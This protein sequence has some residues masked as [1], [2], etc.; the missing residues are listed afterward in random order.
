MLPVG[1]VE[2]CLINSSHIPLDSLS[3]SLSKERASV[4]KL[5]KVNNNK[6]MWG[7][8]QY[9]I[10]N[11]TISKKRG[12]NFQKTTT[13]WK[14]FSLPTNKLHILKYNLN[15][16]RTWQQWKHFEMMLPNYQKLHVSKKKIWT[17]FT[18]IFGEGSKKKWDLSVRLIETVWP[19]WLNAHC[20]PFAHGCII[21]RPAFCSQHCGA[22]S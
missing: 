16:I 12:L 17:A 7:L 22:S 3:L 10:V 20:C 2:C 5:P 18:L 1:D 6:T 14:H 15:Q 4:R 13:L 11:L 19:V 21:E 9:Y 8:A